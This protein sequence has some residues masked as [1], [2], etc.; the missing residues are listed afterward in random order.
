MGG[1]QSGEHRPGAGDTD[2]LADDR[3]DGELGSV[4]VP[5]HAEPG[6][7]AQQRGQQRIGGEVG[8]YRCRVGVGV[9]QPTDA[10]DGGGEVTQVG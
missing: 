10:F 6:V 5:R 7:A 8:Q 2:L 9:Q 3:A 4:G 1:D